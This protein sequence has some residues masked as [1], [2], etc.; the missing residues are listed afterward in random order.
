[1]LGGSDPW[2][3]TE[4]SRPREN[5]SKIKKAF[6]DA[7][8]KAGIINCRFHDLQ[9]A[10]DTNMKKAGVDHSVIMKLTGY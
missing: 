5:P 6:T 1:L 7:C 8:R 9:Q 3:R 10:F 2:I 4:L